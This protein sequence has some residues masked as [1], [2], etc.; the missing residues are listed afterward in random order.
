L[1]KTLS[2]KIA[3]PLCAAMFFFAFSACQVEDEGQFFLNSRLEIKFFGANRE[4]ER[5]C[6]QEITRFLEEFE[7]KAS[8]HLEDSEVSKFN[9]AKAGERVQLSERVYKLFELSMEYYQKTGGAFNHCLYGLSKLWGFM[10]SDGIYGIEELPSQQ[11]VEQLL[12]YADPSLIELSDGAA[13]KFHDAVKVDFGA[14]AKGYALD[15]C[16]QIARSYGIKSALF[17]MA[18]NVYAIGYKDDGAKFSI[19]ITDPRMIETGEEIFA[20]VRLADTSISVSGDY[21]RYFLKGGIRYCHIIDPFTG[22]PVNTGNSV[23]G[24]ISAIVISQNA[25]QADAFSTAV[26]VSGPEEG[27]RLLEQNG[28]CGIIITADKKY[29]VVG[30]VELFGVKNYERAEWEA[31]FGR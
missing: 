4:A 25:A 3:L 26:M 20:G 15:V 31:S 27:K 11:Q 17:N 7:Q 30:D 18:G 13:V 5:L 9:K 6:R 12:S 21:E 29:Y 14:V 16:G 24:I 28:L 19:G 8:A 23:S 22:W 10:E 1:L 2:S